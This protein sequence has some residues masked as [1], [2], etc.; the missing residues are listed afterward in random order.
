GAVGG[1]LGLFQFAHLPER[2]V[3]QNAIA[4]HS[5]VSNDLQNSIEL[6]S[7]DRFGEVRFVQSGQ[8]SE[9]TQAWDRCGVNSAIKGQ[10]QNCLNHSPFAVTESEPLRLRAH[11]RAQ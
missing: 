3:R 9:I 11:T 4:G 10:G 7:T 6:K 5:R 2:G 1:S 8:S